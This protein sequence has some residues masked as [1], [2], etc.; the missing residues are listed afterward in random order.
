[1]PPKAPPGDAYRPGGQQAGFQA[2][3][4]SVEEQASQLNDLRKE[5]NKLND[6]NEKLRREMVRLEKQVA[7]TTSST[8]AFYNQ[9]VNDV[10]YYQDLVKKQGFEQTRGYKK[11][12]AELETER[13]KIKELAAI[14]N[15]K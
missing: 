10:Q 13:D 12:I 1:M 6:E 15:E 2:F 4:M 9:L 11:Q 7:E 3:G 14:E 5:K 8:P